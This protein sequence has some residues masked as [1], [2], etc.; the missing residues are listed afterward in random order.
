MSEKDKKLDFDL[1]FLDEESPKSKQPIRKDHA[2]APETAS[3][4][5]WNWK[6]ISIV[7]GVIIVIIWIAASEDNSSTP[8]STY[9][10]PSTNQVRNVSAGDD[11]VEYGEYRCSRYH[12]DKA[13]ALSPSETEQTLKSAQLSM[14]IRA[15]ELERLQREIENSYVNEYSWQWEIDDYNDNVNTYNSKLTSY[16]RDAT[17]LDSRIDRFNAQVAAHNNYLTQNCT[18]R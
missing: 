1:G 13:V 12:Y 17:A 8:T 18:P 6:T 14:D 11:S 3:S 16:K 10:P 5:K 2:K 15:N 4:T 9:T 7:A